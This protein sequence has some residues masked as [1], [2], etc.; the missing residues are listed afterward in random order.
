MNVGLA[1]GSLI[2]STQR[3]ERHRGCTVLGQT[4]AFVHVHLCCMSTSLGKDFRSSQRLP[5]FRTHSSQ[6]VTYTITLAVLCFRK[7]T[8]LLQNASG[9]YSSRPFLLELHFSTLNAR[10][11]HLGALAE[12]QSSGPQASQALQR[13]G[14][15][16]ILSMVHCSDAQQSEPR[17]LAYDRVHYCCLSLPCPLSL[18]KPP[19]HPPY[20]K[21]S[22]MRKGFGLISKC[23]FSQHKSQMAWEAFQQLR[24]RTSSRW[25]EVVQPTVDSKDELTG[26]QKM[27]E[28][29][30]EFLFSF[31]F[32]L[33]L[34]QFPVALTSRN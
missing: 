28:N 20:S 27:S 30:S 15:K 8:S 7:P 14:D 13:P 12:Q 23:W 34:F 22:R 11:S 3:W 10:E 33:R 25:R 6:A 19:P 26:F 2:W 31:F 21:C 18:L 1:I 29:A 32:N 4:V 17:A 24:L 5:P 9:N 16:L